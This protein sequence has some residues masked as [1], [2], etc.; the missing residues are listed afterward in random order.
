M[1]VVQITIGAAFVVAL[2][3]FSYRYMREE[4][5]NNPIEEL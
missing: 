1:T 3:Y 2:I 4:I 5:K